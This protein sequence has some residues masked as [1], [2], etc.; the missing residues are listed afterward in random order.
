M[1]E[2][3]GSKDWKEE[4][5]EEKTLVNRFLRL[6]PDLVYCSTGGELYTQNNFASQF[7][8]HCSVDIV[9][10]RSGL[11]QPPSSFHLS[12]FCL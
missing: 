9:Y 1:N 4:E 12:Y 7:F 3:E 5:E 11:T 6:T 10:N 8:L 2:E